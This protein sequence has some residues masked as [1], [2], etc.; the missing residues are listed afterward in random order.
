MHVPRGNLE[1]R[2]EGVAPDRAKP[3][4]LYCASGSRSA[5][6]TK[7]LG[8]LGYENVSRSRAASPTGSGNGY[9][10]VRPRVLSPEKRARY[11]RHIAI[12]EVGEEGQLKLLDLFFTGNTMEGKPAKVR[13]HD[14]WYPM[15]QAIII[16][17]ERGLTISGTRLTS[18]SNSSKGVIIESLSRKRARNLTR[19]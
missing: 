17:T 4:V 1:S 16:R 3:L 13:A 11:A 5:F 6:A 8:D 10:V 7:T 15:R 19:R 14:S 12:P 18:H 2:I 9:D